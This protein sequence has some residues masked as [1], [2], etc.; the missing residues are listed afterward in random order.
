MTVPGE[1]IT[2]IVPVIIWSVVGG[3]AAVTL[4]GI[5]V[6]IIDYIDWRKKKK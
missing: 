2:I 4:A 3:F 5:V 1:Y 6:S